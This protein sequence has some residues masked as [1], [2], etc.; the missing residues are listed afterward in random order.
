MYLDCNILETIRIC[1]KTKAIHSGFFRLR[2]DLSSDVC[3]TCA[4]LYK[5]RAEPKARLLQWKVAAVKSNAATCHASPRIPARKVDRLFG[6]A[7]TALPMRRLPEADPESQSV[8][9]R[10]ISMQA[11]VAPCLRLYPA[12]PRRT[13]KAFPHFTHGFI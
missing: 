4:R 11:A 8:E 5:D 13:A 2:S 9:V 10:E 3:S 7:L 6:V 12:G 1:R